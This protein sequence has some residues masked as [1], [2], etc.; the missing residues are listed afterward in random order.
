MLCFCRVCG[1]PVA[2]FGHYLSRPRL[3]AHQQSATEALDRSDSSAVA[4]VMP[5]RRAKGTPIK[6]WRSASGLSWHPWRG[7]P[8]L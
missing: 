8:G 3:S 7:T 4:I 5:R 2:W 1:G 6:V